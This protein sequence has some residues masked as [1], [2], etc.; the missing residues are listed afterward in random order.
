MMYPNFGAVRV[1]KEPFP[2]MYIPRVLQSE[3]ADRVLGWLQTRA[4]WTLRVE[5]FY[6]QYEFSFLA[7]DP[8]PE[9]EGLLRPDFVELVGIA[10]QHGFVI[11][12]ELELIDI[13]AHL[14]KP[15][16]I[17][18]IHNDYLDGEET[19]RLL[20]QLNA[21][22]DVNQGGLLMLF[23]DAK[24]ESLRRTMVP[25]HGSGFA[26]EISP[27]S[28]HAVSSITGG[29]RFTVVYTFRSTLRNSRRL[30]AAVDRLGQA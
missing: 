3:D 6:Q 19:H 10:L 26:F 18:R 28:F 21:G 15:G 16:Q 2:H 29:E 13:G 12:G 8:E 7:T 27:S 30:A 24:P 9:I 5:N 4:P 17:I 14:L 25:V 23:G 22:W 11:Q 20:I 1:V